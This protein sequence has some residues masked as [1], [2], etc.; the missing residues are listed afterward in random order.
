MSGNNSAAWITESKSRPL[1]VDEA[2]FPKP[3]PK[4][5]VIKNKAV[6]INPVDWKIQDSGYFVSNYPAILGTDVAGEVVELGSDVKDFKEGDRVLAHCIGLATQNPQDNAFQLYTNVPAILTS[7]LPPASSFTEGVVLPLAISTASAGLYQPSYLELPFPTASPK[8]SN[9][10]ILVWGGSSSVGSTAIQLAVASGVTVIT[11][12]S[13]HNHSYCKNIG[14][15]EVIDYNSSSVA[16]DIVKAIKS[17]GKEFAGIYDSI[18]LPESFKHCFEVL[19]KA[20]GSKKMATVLPPPEDK[21]QDVDA[22]GV[23]A[24][25]IAME[26]KAVGHAV[27]NDY[28]PAAL[29][30]GSL[31]FLPEP[32]VVGK[33]LEK[34]QEALDLQKKGVSARKVVVEL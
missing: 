23:F 30:N 10:V 24:I 15:A 28:V 16:E 17:S 14:A 25:T 6:A 13:K 5:L 7:P 2:P 32:L 1:K 34:V 4:D 29:L 8:E 9:K 26:H 22:K 20:G 3:G 21:P 33:G 31:K 19:E 12:A 11:T 18:S 27:W